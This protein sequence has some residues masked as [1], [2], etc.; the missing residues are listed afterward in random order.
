VMQ[1]VDHMLSALQS[2]AAP[3]EPVAPT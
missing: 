1:A 2:S 3:P